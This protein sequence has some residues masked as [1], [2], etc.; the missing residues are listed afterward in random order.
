MTK[1]ST[2]AGPLFVNVSM[3]IVHLLK[4]PRIINSADGISRV[5]H[6]L[7]ISP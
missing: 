7:S 4:R 6:P 5:F 3:P 2:C 1:P